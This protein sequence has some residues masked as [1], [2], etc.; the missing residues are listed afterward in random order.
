M[1]S[2][3]VTDLT[4]LREVSCARAGQGSAKSATSTVTA[5]TAVTVIYL[6]LLSIVIVFVK[7]IIPLRPPVVVTVG[8]DDVAVVVGV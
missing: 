3:I 2:S 5:I 1:A 7:F 6:S 8:G 4:K